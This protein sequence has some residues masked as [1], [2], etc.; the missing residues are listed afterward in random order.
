MLDSTTQMVKSIDPKGKSLFDNVMESKGP[1]VLYEMMPIDEHEAFANVPEDQRKGV[2]EEFLKDGQ[3]ER[4][5][6]RNSNGRSAITWRFSGPA[7]CIARCSPTAG[8]R[9]VGI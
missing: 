2:P 9:P 1:W 5:T 7:R 3:A 8:N 4:Q 6:A